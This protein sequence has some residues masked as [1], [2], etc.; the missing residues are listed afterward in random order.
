MRA[1]GAYRRPTGG[2][3]V[4]AREPSTLGPDDGLGTRLGQAGAIAIAGE[5]S[6]TASILRELRHRILGSGGAPRVRR[7]AHEVARF[8]KHVYRTKHAKSGDLYIAFAGVSASGAVNI[9]LCE[10][11]HFNNHMLEGPE[12][13]Q[14]VI[15]GRDDMRQRVRRSLTATP[16]TES[17]DAFAQNLNAAVGS[18]LQA[19]GCVHKTTTIDAD[20]VR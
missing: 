1:V 12:A 19:V 6:A 15:L 5:T 9:W 13:Q 20:G 8:A 18:E 2:V 14:P 3:L 17:L 4:A 7:I 16:D 10:S 11:P